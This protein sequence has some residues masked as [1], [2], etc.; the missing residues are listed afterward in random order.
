MTDR[1]AYH[2]EIKKLEFYVLGT[3]ENY[4]D[5]AVSI[6]NKELFKGDLPVPGGC[7]DPNMGTTDYSW[8]CQHCLNTKHRCIGH[9]G[10]LDLR[11]SV[12]SPLFRDNIIKWLKIVCFKCGRLIV[13]K[14]INT[15]SVKLLGE[16]VKLSKG[17]DKCPWPDCGEPH[18]NISKDKY[19]PSII[20]A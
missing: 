12:K 4:I 10:S 15:A 19:K 13:D 2:S 7:Y 17:I 11:Y 5:S 6:T 20:Y 18:P 8:A 9:S 3:E 1:Y 16:Y 14:D